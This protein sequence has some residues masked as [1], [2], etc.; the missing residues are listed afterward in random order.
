MCDFD[1]YDIC[2]AYN[3]YSVLWGWDSYTHGIQARLSR[4]RWRDPSGERLETLSDNAKRIF[5]ALVRRREHDSIA[6]DRLRRRRPDVFPPWPGT[7]N[8]RFSYAEGS[9]A[10]RAFV[11][12]LGI[13]PAVLDAVVRS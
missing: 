8:F 12:R 2:A 4:F 7:Q 5:G 13:D 3:M 9:T 6:Y 10:Y 11:R 1:R